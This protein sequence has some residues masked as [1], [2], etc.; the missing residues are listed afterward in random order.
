V[1]TMTMDWQCWRQHLRAG[2]QGEL[3]W[4]RCI[5]LGPFLMFKIKLWFFCSWSNTRLCL[6]FFWFTRPRS[7]FL[8]T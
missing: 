3:I 2:H 4:S 5:F 6:C 1:L 8:N 7:P